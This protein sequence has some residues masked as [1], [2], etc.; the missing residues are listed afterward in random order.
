MFFKRPANKN[1]IGKRKLVF[2]FGVNDSEYM[3]SVLANG[4]RYECDIYRTWIYML[5]RAYDPYYANKNPTYRNVF[6][7]DEWLRFSNFE[8]WYI[9]NHI[10]GTD[11]DKDIKIKGNKTYSP[12]A[13][14]FIPQSLN[15]L[16]T[17][18]VNHRG[19]YPIGVHFNKNNKKYIA[20]VCQNGKRIHLGTFDAPVE[21]HNAYKAAKN[22]VIEQAMLDYPKFAKYLEQHMYDL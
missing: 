14:L 18:R 16:L 5:R 4:R 13:C 20:R 6:V 11:L 8:K 15:K 12:D 10:N 3:T 7:C 22:N 1:S 19:R 9:E 17:D 21:A 2:G